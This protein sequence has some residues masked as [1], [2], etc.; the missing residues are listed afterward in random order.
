MAMKI[1]ALTVTLLA[2]AVSPTAFAQD[3]ASEIATLRDQLLALSQRLDALESSNDA[4]REENARLKE[5]SEQTASEVEAVAQQMEKA[6]GASW[7]DRI[8]LKGDFRLRNEGIDQEGRANRTRNRIRARASIIAQVN[9]DVEAVL[10][11]ASGGDDPVSTNQTLGGGGSTKGMN[12]DLAYVAWSGLEN[13]TIVG[14]K[15]KNNLYKPGGNSLLWDG[16]W[17][18]EGVGLSWANGDWFANAIGTWLESDTRSG[19]EFAWGAQA[20]LARKLSD[21]VKL[22]AGLAWYD[23]NTA[24]GGTFYGDADDF[25][26]NSYDPLSNTYLHD[27]ELLEVFAE[28]GFKLGG[29]PAGLFFDYV[30]NQDADAF[31]T[32]Y[33]VGFEYG[34]AKAPGDWEGA[35]IYQD[36]EADAVFGL[37]TDSDFAGGGTDG[38]G[39]ILKAGY[40]VAK[41][42]NANLTYFINENGANAG[43][44]RDYDRMQIDLAFKY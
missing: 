4:L 9:D 36:L 12:L 10:G 29:R 1:I 3:A 6:A 32:G 8:K 5:A 24:G 11:F 40:S 17:T 35:V 22:T 23:F 39:Y 20:G 19:A 13:T 18:P 7:A 21:G 14:G 34:A 25:F 38:K 15:F 37:L 42:W 44:Q 43:N 27:Y 16:D 41:N 31:D 28:L 33:S 26:G 2:L 30:Q